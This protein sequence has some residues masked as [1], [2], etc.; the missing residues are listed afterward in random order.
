MKR[1]L[2]IAL[3][4][5]GLILTS[6]GADVQA[7]ANLLK[8][9]SFEMKGKESV[10]KTPP[11]W[12]LETTS[13]AG[14]RKSPDSKSTVV[15]TPGG[16]T[17]E[18]NAVMKLDA[19]DKVMSVEQ[20][21]KTNRIE[22][23]GEFV[24]S[25]WLRA[26]ETIDAQV[27]G[28]VFCHSTGKVYSNTVS[29]K[30]TDVWR[31]YEVQVT[32]G[33]DPSGA[34]RVEE[35]PATGNDYV[36]ALVTLRTPGINV[37]V[38]DVRL[39]S[40]TAGSRAPRPPKPPVSK[41]SPKA[42]APEGANLLK[43]ASF[44]MK[45]A[46]S[47]GNTPPHWTKDTLSRKNVRTSP[48]TKS[49]LVVAPGG[50]TG[51]HEAAMKLDESDKWIYVEQRAATESTKGQQY[52]L[53]VW[54]K[55]DEAITVTLTVSAYCP[56]LAKAYTA[57]TY[58]KL[59]DVWQK[60]ETRVTI[61]G[62]KAR[63]DAIPG[64]GKGYV[65]AIIQVQNPGIN[66][67]VDDVGLSRF[68]PGEKGHVKETR[69]PAKAPAS[70]KAVAGVAADGNMLANPSFET[71]GQA[72]V[73]KAPSGWRVN[74]LSQ[75][76]VRN[77]S[78]SKSS[79]IVQS[80]GRASPQKVVMTR[81]PADDWVFLDQ[82]INT[83]L[84]S[85]QEYE[86]SAWMR[87]DDR[88]VVTTVISVY[89]EGIKK[90]ANKH[91]Y[92]E[93]TDA[94]QEFRVA[95][96]LRSAAGP[97]GVRGIM[98]LPMGSKVDASTESVRVEIDDVRLVRRGPEGVA[99]SAIA[100][101]AV[102]KAPKRVVKRVPRPAA[103]T[104]EPA[105]GKWL[106]PTDE[107][108]T[109]HIKWMKPA[110]AE[111]ARVLFITYRLGMREVVELCQRFDI[112]R[113]VFALERQSSFAGNVE[114]AQFK[115][116]KGTNPRAQ[117][118]RLREK[119]A[120][121]TDCVV[122]GNIPW[123]ALPDW[124]RAAIME[125]VASGTGLA[126]FVTTDDDYRGFLRQHEKTIENVNRNHGTSFS[127]WNDVTS[128][129]AGGPLAAALA[130]RRDIDS[131]VILG[132]FPYKRLPA[133][134]QYG[135]DEAFAA[136]TLTLAQ[137]GKGRIAFLGGY[138]CPS[139]QMVA[140]GVGAAFPQRHM[141]HYDY[142][143]A[144]AGKMI[145]WAAGK[146]QEVRVLASDAPVMTA[147]R[148]EISRVRFVL[149]ADA[150]GSVD[151][152]FALRCA[153]SGDL[154]KS[155][156]KRLTLKAGENRVSFDAP[157]VPAGGYFADV[158]VKRGG[159]TITFGSR[160]VQVTSNS[161]IAGLVLRSD[162]FAA[163]DAIKHYSAGDAIAG[164]VSVEGAREGLSLEVSQRDNYGRVVARE[165]FPLGTDAETVDFTLTPLSRLSV[166]QTVEA[167]LLEDDAVLDTRQQ[168]FTYNDLFPDGD[169]VHH[170]L[171]E[172]YLGNTYLVDHMA[173]V[174]A[175]GGV[176]LW[177]NAHWYDMA[178][179]MISIGAALRANMHELPNLFYAPPFRPR[180]DGHPIPVEGGGH[181]RKPCLTDPDY[182]GKLRELY[183][184]VA[185]EAR[186][187]A[188]GHYTFGSEGA[189]TE[190]EIEVCFSDT[191]IA[192]FRDYVKSE[193]GTLDR[194]N[195]EYGT[196]YGDW[197]EITPVT[198]QTALDTHRIPMWF[199]F[200]R[201]MD[202]VWADYIGVIHDVFTEVIPT[203]KVGYDSSNDAGHCPRL[204]GL[205]GDDY[206]KISQ[207]ITLHAP[208]FWPLQ[209]DCARD[210]ARPKT[211]IG[212]GWH[213]GYGGIT[214][215]GRN[216][217]WNAWLTWYTFLRGANSIW[218]WQGSGGSGGEITGTTIAPDFTW[219]GHMD[220]ALGA[221]QTIQT[222]IGKLA[223]A[224]DRA[225]DGVAVLYSPASMLM[226]N[227]TP[228][229]PQRWDSLSALTVILPESN[230]QYRMISSS[231]IEAGILREGAIKL[232]YLP[233]A[234]ALSSKEADEILAFAKGGGGVVADLRPGVADGHGKPYAKGALDA[235]FGVTQNTATPSPQDGVVPLDD[236]LA[237]L[238]GVLPLA[239]IDASLRV[240]GGKALTTVAGAPGVIVN[241]F[242]E[243]KAT[244]LN[245][246]VSDYIKH[247]LMLGSKSVIRFVDEDTAAAT[248]SFIR[249]VFARSG[250][251]PAVA[252]TP[253]TP[254]C[255]V[256]RFESGGVQLLGLLQ[257][258]PPYMPGVGARP[259]EELEDLAWYESAVTLRLDAPK[260][261]Y[262]VLAGEYLGHLKEIPR[263]V[264]PGI[265]HVLAALPYKVESITL[266]PDKDTYAQ[267][268][269][270]A[271]SAQ[272]ET[273][274]PDAGLHVLRIE[275]TDPD[276]ELA[277]MYTMKVKAEGGRYP[278][279]LPLALNEKIGEW[280]I[281][282]RD[283][284]T[285]VC[286]EAAVKILAA[287]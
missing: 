45:G 224:M 26:D 287:Q 70:P 7:G 41:K 270:L 93:L 104:K 64:D 22:K 258:I 213:G 132:A 171:W 143:L 185:E 266:V 121:D 146:A 279:S 208:Y 82:V 127:S 47:V 149:E 264:M 256:Y 182:L 174:I 269:K 221:I 126:G 23:G 38:D 79:V 15:V 66:V 98:T 115:D 80:G 34:T 265:T 130:E 183:H 119:L 61:A 116:F 128:I 248:A 56:S 111:P 217:L 190:K 123:V 276:G 274:G 2:A 280:K 244:L 137:H 37:E 141:V 177:W 159:K 245:F 19:G 18:Y 179:G 33:E 267:G 236:T 118:K 14:V 278:G 153:D 161:R 53:S 27:Y 136:G 25:V 72:S 195:N 102:R 180:L 222:G 1:S 39:V 181:I 77:A 85:G 286:A 164:Q 187:Y 227:L 78:D 86:L 74:T 117:E 246:A 57:H 240:A 133:F 252:M 84:A 211:F 233:N 68:G 228:D 223:M 40:G 241:D 250:V 76:K 219:Y 67:E 8:N 234:Q 48:D 238:D 191:C 235:L 192:R 20:R 105:V 59:S 152:E 249:A 284:A 225:D 32:V 134:A 95:V 229:F 140:P 200:R 254:G 201:S 29:G 124:A 172:G 60:F 65:R 243:G 73:G 230:F 166:L 21:W 42:A 12:I 107:Y 277:K 186:K 251:T 272:V 113:E 138:S 9:P 162:D 203:A 169:D 114:S 282:V 231:Q 220:Q 120:L 50:H 30:L 109:P 207:G 147:D 214:R 261:V 215:G 91:I 49:T 11:H 275:L 44:E 90:E 122:I 89:G 156:R 83:N 144:L 36:R 253:Q 131:K 125:K 170:V 101:R 110:H 129:G 173:K 158:W 96:V 232:L 205:G 198:Y 167:R 43:N 31:E 5:G 197:S 17:G 103:R 150:R 218:T 13:Q 94:W 54:L 202:S 242:G 193:Y 216:G 257:E 4:L 100:K 71:G 52:L 24:V 55:A 263:A 28:A 35:I 196:S 154:L 262:D 178:R 87:S 281:T 142:Y 97:A 199:D 255:H 58:C 6:T 81:D 88:A 237:G 163:D 51:K 285:G 69:A 160:F 155:A 189:F 212:G 226:A 16:H 62:A 63:A 204:G 247:K 157:P 188:T 106:E 283:V 46:A 3:V 206:W 239:A 165:T 268:E 135:D 75:D 139:Y 260:H 175:D 194:L 145:N 210:F 271:F 209:L 92:C 273:D 259:E 99:A 10:G 151:L 168:G 184:G 112:K 108:V 176:D 148:S